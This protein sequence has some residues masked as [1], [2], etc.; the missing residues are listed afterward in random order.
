MTGRDEGVADGADQARVVDVE[1]V[2][3]AGV[4]PQVE[5]LEVVLGGLLGTTDG[6]ASSPARRLAV[7]AVA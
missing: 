5:C 1:V 4:V 7:T 6:A 3:E 2:G